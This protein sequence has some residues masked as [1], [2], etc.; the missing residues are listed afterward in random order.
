MSPHTMLRMIH[1]VRHLKTEQVVYRLYYRF[2]KVRVT[3]GREYR[4]RVWL[5]TSS[6]PELL[7]SRMHAH[8]K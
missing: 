4:Q 5:E 6:G 7:R 8:S 3:E 1:T 2:A